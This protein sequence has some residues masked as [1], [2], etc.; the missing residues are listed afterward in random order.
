MRPNS[1]LSARSLLF[2]PGDRPD[3]VGK[4]FASA[5]DAVI[6]DLEDAVRPENKQIARSVVASFGEGP[7][8]SSA[9]FLVRVNPFRSADFTDDV[10]AA[11]RAGAHGIM[12][13]KFVPGPEAGRADEA[14]SAIEARLGTAGAL[15]VV[16]LIESAAGLQGLHG[17]SGE[18]ELPPRFRR[19]AFGAAD[20]Y[21]DLRIA[22]RTSGVY[23]D[24]AMAA[25]VV[26]SAAAGL[27]SPLDSPHFALDD[28][29]GLAVRAHNARD[30]GFGGALCIHPK[31]IAI[32]NQEFALD[33][34]E[35]AWAE[36]VLAAWSAPG[37][38]GRGAIRV[39]D[40]LIDEAM[41]R[42]VRQILDQ[43]D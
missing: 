42:R 12:L 31:Q 26:A 6:V 37:N 34:D 9:V 19:L 21:A 40:E 14:M 35:R 16:G 22:Y 18:Q 11:I 24:L 25:L 36:R 4:A 30:L 1:I 8:A 39:D 20:F 10:E 29:E 17:I 3:R 38:S 15:P 2:V 32:L 43:D 33:V 5:A 27:S 7:L 41:L 23:T 28:D 13:P